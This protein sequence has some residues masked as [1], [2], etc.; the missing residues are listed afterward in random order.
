[1]NLQKNCSSVVFLEVPDSSNVTAQAI[2][3]VHRIG[4]LKQQNIYIVT[5]NHSYD[6]KLQSNA[7]SKMY[8]QIAG[9]SNISCTTREVQKVMKQL[10]A[11]KK[12]PELY[13][14]GDEDDDEDDLMDD[15]DDGEDEAARLNTQALRI[16]QNQTVSRLYQ[17]T[18]GQR[19]L[20]HAWTNVR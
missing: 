19:S 3:R 7:A 9:Q 6:Q 5:K 18:F 4:Q 8:G 20:R 12:K 2:G 13:I 17:I 11:R 14:S 1:M 10:K 15:N 16:A